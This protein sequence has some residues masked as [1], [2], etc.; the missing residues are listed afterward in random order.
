MYFDIQVERTEYCLV[1]E[2]EKGQDHENLTNVE[3][4]HKK[5]TE[6]FLIYLVLIIEHS[7]SPFPLFLIKLIFF[8]LFVILILG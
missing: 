5:I 2:S 6:Y 8:L 4:L 3:T 7:N 1:F